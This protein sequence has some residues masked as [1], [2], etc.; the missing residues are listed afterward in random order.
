MTM[1]V[2][3]Q[4]ENSANSVEALKEENEVLRK[5]IQEQ[6]FS[7]DIIQGND[8]MTKFYTGLPSRG[9][10]LHIFCFLSPYMTSR[11]P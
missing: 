4:I 9:V 11:L 3:L 10:F 8:H 5:Q 2:C 1:E 6:H 7:V